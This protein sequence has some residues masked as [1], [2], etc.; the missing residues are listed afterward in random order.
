MFEMRRDCSMTGG[1]SGRVESKTGV[2]VHGTF[3]WLDSV[4]VGGNAEDFK[5]L[6]E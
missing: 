4:S 6:T 2:L 3:A 5:L 1:H